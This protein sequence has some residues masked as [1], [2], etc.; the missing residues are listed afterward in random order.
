MSD[1]DRLAAESREDDKRE[2]D[3]TDLRTPE[4]AADGFGIRTAL[5]VTGVG[6]LI[7]AV[8]LISSPSFQ[9]CSGLDN[10]K[11]R[12]ACYESLRSA[13]LKPPVK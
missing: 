6:F 12:V 5:L 9:K 1:L 13:V 7:A 10:L 11:D 8:W 2:D 4:D 3:N